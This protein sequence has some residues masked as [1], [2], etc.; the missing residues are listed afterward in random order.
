MV[1]KWSRSRRRNERQGVLVEE[2]ALGQSPAQTLADEEERIAKRAKAATRREAQDLVISQRSRRPF[3]KR[4]LIPRP[5][6]NR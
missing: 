5:A 6:S 2:A 4:S 3:A 1:V